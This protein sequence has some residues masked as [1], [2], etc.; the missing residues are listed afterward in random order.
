MEEG[1]V[2]VVLSSEGPV[3]LTEEGEP[4]VSDRPRPP[5]VESAPLT[6]PYHSVPPNVMVLK[7]DQLFAWARK[8]SLWPLTFGI[9]CCAIEMIGTYMSNYDLDRFGTVP[10]PSPR[11]ADV[12]IVAGTVNLKV[13]KVIK[14]LWEQMPMPK[15]CI[16]MGSCAV[17]GGPFYPYMNVVEG[18]DR[19]VPVDVYVPGCPPRPDALIDGILKL[20]AKIMAD[21]KAGVWHKR[22]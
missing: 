20:Q 8:S 4:L 1:R 2:G 16:A 15:W 3:P 5:Q 21:A 7:A 6:N 19:V 10:F 14:R 22:K 12:M 9:A 13:A 11:Q 18:V 17:C